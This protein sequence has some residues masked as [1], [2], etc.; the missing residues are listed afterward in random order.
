M[1]VHDVLAQVD[2]APLPDEASVV[3]AVQFVV[4]AVA[5]GDER[6][7]VLLADRCRAARVRNVRVG[8]DE[9]VEVVVQ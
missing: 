9:V 6:R 3:E 8:N 4:V 5:G 1:E 2:G 7:V